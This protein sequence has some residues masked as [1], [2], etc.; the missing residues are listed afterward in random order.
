[1]YNGTKV[2]D[3]HGHIS[4]PPEFFAHAAFL[5]AANSAARPLT[6]PDE[7]LAA[8][9]EAHLKVLDERRVD[10]Q[11]VGPRPFAQFLWARPHV[12]AAWAR[13]TNDTIARAVQMHPDRLVG[14]AHLPQNSEIETSNCVAELERCVQELGFVGAYVDPDPGGNQQ[15]P[16]MHESYW[17]PL[18]EAA[19]RLNVALMVH[20]TGTFDRR[21]EVLPHNYQIASVVEEYIATQILS[22]TDVF[23]RFPDLRVIVCHCGGS[24]DR[25]IKTDPH[26]GQR[27]VSRNLYFDTCAHDEG[28]LSA[29]FRQRGVDQMLFGTEAPGSGGAKRPETGR[30]ADDLVPV[31]AGLPELSEGDKIKV[32]NTNAKRV[33]PQL[34]RF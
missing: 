34:E 8:S 7:R 18:Y 32:F 16:G 4:T 33:F 20:P 27:D 21:V 2:L 19:Q 15:T 24:L 14:M 9:Q 17:F 11:L 26:L 23:D 5:M 30:S 25:W 1:M 29:A 10:V 6:I 22:R 3:V 28:F 12:Q 31:I 13:A